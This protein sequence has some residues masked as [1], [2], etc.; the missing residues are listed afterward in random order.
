[1]LETEGG[2]LERLYPIHEPQFDAVRV[3][4]LQPR[5]L[6]EVVFA[7]HISQEDTEVLVF[8][9][10]ILH[11]SDIA[12]A[13]SVVLSLLHFADTCRLIHAFPHEVPLRSELPIDLRDETIVVNICSICLL[14]C[15]GLMTPSL[16]LRWYSG[17][18]TNSFPTWFCT[19]E[20][21]KMAMSDAGMQI[22]S[23]SFSSIPLQ[24]SKSVEIIAAVAAETGLPVMPNEAAIV[25]TLIGRSGLIFELV[26]ISEIIGSSE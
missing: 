8:D 15:S 26:A 16:T 20:A 2:Y 21:T 12:E 19:K 22:I 17:S 14:S 9:G 18:S 10:V 24:P 6:T 3:V 4:I 5:L 11:T 7:A 23:T 1:M 13:L 25:A